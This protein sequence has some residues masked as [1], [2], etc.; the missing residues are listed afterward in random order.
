MLVGV[1][2]CSPET[3]IK[4]LSKRMLEKGLEAVVVLDP[5]EGHAMGVVSLKELVTA[6]SQLIGEGVESRA[7][8]DS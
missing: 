3:P 6:Y 8:N 7:E 2:T 4:E 5:L 1:P